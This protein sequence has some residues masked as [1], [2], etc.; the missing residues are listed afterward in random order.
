[1]R[2]RHSAIDDP[3]AT[4]RAARARTRRLFDIITPDAYYD[5]PIALRN[6]IVFY[7]GHLPAFSIEFV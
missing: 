2:L 1:M 5:R 3:V 4:W 6:P 7:E